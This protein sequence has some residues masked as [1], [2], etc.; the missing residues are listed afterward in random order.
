MKVEDVS[1]FKVHFYNMPGFIESI[2]ETK[3]ILI[4]YSFNDREAKSDTIG[5]A[6]GFLETAEQLFSG[7]V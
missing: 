6:I 3:V 1:V 7:Y 4:G 2:A 5:A